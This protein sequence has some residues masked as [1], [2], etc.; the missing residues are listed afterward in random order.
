VMR[1]LA[2]YTI[3]VLAVAI[4]GGSIASASYVASDLISNA[5]FRNAG[6]MSSSQIQSFL[7]S[8]GSGLAGYTQGGKR[9]SQIIYEAAGSYG[10]NPQVVLATLQK[11]QSLITDPEPSSTQLRSAMGYG[12][13]DSADCNADYYGFSNQ[14]HNGTWQLRYNYERASGNNTWWNNGSYACG[15]ATHF[16]STGL[17][18]G[19]NVTFY[20]AGSYPDKTIK[21][22]NAATAS[23]YCYTPHVGPYWET[24]YSGSYNFV[25]SF[26]SWFG[27]TRVPRIF[28]TSNNPQAYLFDGAT[29]YYRIPSPEVLFAYG[30]DKNDIG[31]VS[32]ST[33]SS[34]TNRGTLKVAARF[35]G[36]SIYLIDRGWKIHFPSREIYEAYGYTVGDEASLDVSIANLLGDGGTVS[37]V[38][39]K[40]EDDSKY[41]MDAGKRRHIS[42]MTAYTTLGSP[43][44]SS[45]ST[46]TLSSTYTLS[47]ELGTPLLANNSFARDSD[48]GETGFW[49][50]NLLQTFSSDVINQSGVSVYTGDAVGQL[51]HTATAYAGALVKTAGPRYFLIDSRQVFELS[52]SQISA[53]GFP[54]SMFV[55][56]NTGFATAVADRLNTFSPVV[57]VNNSNEVYL[58]KDR[59]RYQIANP[60]A[61]YEQGYTFG[62]VVNINSRTASYLPLSSEVIYAKG[63]LVRIN[64]GEA[65]YMIVSPTAKLQVPSPSAMSAYGLSFSSVLDATSS[66]V[67]AYQTTGMLPIIVKDSSGTVWLVDSQT[68]R[69]IAST[70]HTASYYNLSVAS[71]KEIPAAVLDDLPTGQT[72]SPVI[73]ADGDPKVYKIEGGARRWFTSRQA[74]EDAGYA[75]SDI[76]QV[77]T[78]TRDSFPLGANI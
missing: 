41:L 17:Y 31:L 7:Q 8:K 78:Y 48:T 75:S 24:G 38:I 11:E 70:Y 29:G 6:S 69:S 65:V 54:D 61:L 27:S 51:S 56:V 68:K 40:Y 28:R 53:V 5:V 52:P 63:S 1:R 60:A 73:Q 20:S 26:E 42:S 4:L 3:S 21:I 74:L 32:S 2:Q 39:N 57:R 66:G 44:Y 9:A 37:E 64:G 14:V 46:T 50:G 55:T 36:D 25:T 12:C 33:V 67:S 62:D 30:Y 34:L 49:S 23:L 22:A 47:R 58:A 35:G 59:K 18:P 77:S 19:R 13:P 76:R 16:Y 71:L 43:V 45:R 15:G 10:I 72:M